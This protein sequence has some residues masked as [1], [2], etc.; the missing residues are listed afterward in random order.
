MKREANKSAIVYL[1]TDPDREGEAIAW[2]ILDELG[3]KDETTF[4]ITF[5]EITKS[6]VQKAVAAPAKINIDRV[7]PEARALLDRVVGYP[8]SGLLGKKVAGAA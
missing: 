8:L 6:A 2:H 3:L 4:R 7:K 5:N 1:A